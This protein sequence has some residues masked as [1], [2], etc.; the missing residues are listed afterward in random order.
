MWPCRELWR[1]WDMIRQRGSITKIRTELHTTSDNRSSLKY[2]KYFDDWLLLHILFLCLKKYDSQK[3]KSM[4][5]LYCRRSGEFKLLVDFLFFWEG[6]QLVWH[7][8]FFFPKTLLK[9]FGRICSL[10]IFFCCC[11]FYPID[12]GKKVAVASGACVKEKSNKTADM[13]L[14]WM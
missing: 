10:K 5:L 13:C 1:V 2:W 7:Q 6:R 8:D 3:T 9:K 4:H 14:C 11:C 12:M